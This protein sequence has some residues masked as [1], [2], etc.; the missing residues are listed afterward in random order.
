LSRN[1][2]RGGGLSVCRIDCQACR[3]NTIGFCRFST[4]AKSIRC[5]LPSRC[6]MTMMSIYPGTYRSTHESCRL[7]SGRIRPRSG[8]PTAARSVRATARL[9]AA[10]MRP[11]GSTARSRSAGI[12]LRGSEVGF[13]LTEP[14]STSSRF[15]S[16]SDCQDHQA[17][18][19]LA[20]VRAT[21]F[22][23]RTAAQATAKAR[24]ARP[25]ILIGTTESK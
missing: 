24:C 9:R 12:C 15:P 25:G 16:A 5:R 23:G 7:A 11:A 10:R 22:A 2:V 21:F 14:I 18:R 20:S 19:T 6:G 3:T 17:D 13:Q 4:L 1:A 8:L